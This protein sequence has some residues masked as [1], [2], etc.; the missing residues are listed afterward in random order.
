VTERSITAVLLTYNEEIHIER[1]IRSLL[2]VA[3]KIFVVDSFSTDRTVD[4]A[5]SLGAVVKQ[6]SWKN[7]SDQFQWGLENCGTESNWIM[8][9]DADEF[10][11]P[12]LQ[13]ELLTLLSSEIPDEVIGFYI[14][15]KVFFYGKWIRHG[16][17]YPHTLLRIWRNGNGRIE[18]RWMDE[19]IVLPA[20]SKTRA[21][22]GHLVDEN[23]K[24]ITF[25]IAKHN[26]Y[27][28]REM[29]DLLNDKYHLMDRDE[30][31]KEL[32]DPQARRKRIIK[33]EV[34]AKLPVGIRATLYFFY[35]YIFRFGFLDGGKGFIWHFMQG[36]WYRM[37]VD[38]KLM[39]IE[40]RS[41]G[42]PAKMRKLLYKDYGIKL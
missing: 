41:G 36:Y 18:Q 37:L 34:Y 26:A 3:E 27:A 23:L 20:G 39:E 31:L 15:R 30:S 16:G 21:L 33:D 14:R 35:R 28:S 38:V 13:Q 6:R 32:D 22:K 5:E 2:P 42:D 8:R 7:Y 4:I 17:F 19:H 25:W 29:V 1:C 24:G 12:E 9:M 10:L 11:E 40:E